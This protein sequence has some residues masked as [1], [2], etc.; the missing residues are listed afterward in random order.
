MNK[1]EFFSQLSGSWDEFHSEPGELDRL[2]EFSRHFRLQ[3][4]DRVLDAGC[5]SGRLIPV[6]FDQIGCEGTLVELDFAKGMLAA[7]QEKP[8][9]DH[10]RFVLGDLHHL[11][12]PD[13]ELDKVIALAVLPHIEDKKV[14]FAEFHRVLK[15]GGLLI[16]AHQMGRAA[17]DRM[18]G[19][20]GEA[21]KRDLLPPNAV[22]EVLLA[23]AGFREI[24]ICDEEAHYL[25]WAR[26]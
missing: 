2:R 16:I 21:V 9:G 24:E 11:T 12:L 17:L 6:V 5:G 23:Q 15:P 8:H 4:G 7:A 3:A 26:A 20:S 10:V 18:H 1:H 13:G 19:E 25:A 14:A 22:L